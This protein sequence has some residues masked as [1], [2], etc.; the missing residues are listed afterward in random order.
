MTD[1]AV[2]SSLIVQARPE[3]LASL[4]EAIEALPGAEIHGHDER[5][6]LIVV[7][8][9]ANDAAL[10]EAM[11]RIGALP[12]ALSVSLVY[13]HS[14]RP[15]QSAGDNGAPRPQGDPRCRAPS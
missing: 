6:R 3:A 13:H 10:G 9:S 2:I 4:A 8:E 7:L 1:P 15:P 12:G 5:G 11:S 14:E